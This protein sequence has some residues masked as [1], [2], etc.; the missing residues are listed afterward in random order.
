MDDIDKDYDLDDLLGMM[1]S[2][3]SPMTDALVA[4]MDDE[5]VGGEGV[6]EVYI[7][8][9]VPAALLSRQLVEEVGQGGEL[10][11]G[12]VELV[13][14]APTVDECLRSYLKDPS[15]DNLQLLVLNWMGA[16]DGGEQILDS[17][18]A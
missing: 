16:R 10:C 3:I 14:Y 5:P 15:K 18:L 11:P 9:A 8:W 1:D 6:A 12:L 17:L 4:L 13:E 7:K 2:G